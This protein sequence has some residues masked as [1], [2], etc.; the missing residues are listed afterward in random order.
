MN[1]PSAP[2]LGT[3]TLVS[4]SEAAARWLRGVIGQHGTLRLCAAEPERLAERLGTERP[5]LVVIDF[6]DT[7]LVPAA[8]LAQRA[9]LALPE[10]AVV[11]MGRAAEPGT[12]LAALRAGARDFLDTEAPPA[13]ALAALGRLVRSPSAPRAVKGTVVTLVGAR[14]GVGTSTLAAHLAVLLEEALKPEQRSAALLDLG[15][16][17]GDSQVL[18]ETRGSFS[19]AEAARN[20]HR[21]DATFVQ[22]AL[23]RHS[24]GLA[25]LSLPG[26]V[27]ELRELSHAAS[28][29]VTQR[30]R[31]FVDVQLIDL[32]GFANQEF[33]A[34]VAAISEHC[35]LVCDQGAPSV[36]SA[37][38]LTRALRARGLR[39]QLV[40]NK[41][42]EAVDPSP[43]QIAERLDLP[44]AA[45]LP[46]RSTALLQAMNTGRLLSQAAPG[47]PYVKAVRQL[48]GRV[49]PVSEAGAA[50]AAA[51]A[52]STPAQGLKQWFSSL[53]KTG[54]GAA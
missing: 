13:D 12:A 33:I 22:S 3:L 4:D 21:I 27:A 51:A 36:I 23:P 40:V 17:V 9:A 48:M 32:G 53:R 44:L 34:Q 39:P 52:G 2:T 18:L 46:N 7:V 15:I 19:F 5:G 10:A 37:L 14:A 8:E 31:S 11:A 30:L 43:A 6:S 26:N 24:S 29:S 1:A 41:A 47:D 28:V 49:A 54:R 38:E 20:Q 45:V 50:A 35:L 42:D 16:P 25:V